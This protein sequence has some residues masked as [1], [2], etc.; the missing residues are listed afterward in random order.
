[1]DAHKGVLFRHFTQGMAYSRPFGLAEDDG[2]SETDG[3]SMKTA[4]IQPLIC[5]AINAK[6]FVDGFE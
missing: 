3:L 2:V 6:E 1:M 5:S 4:S